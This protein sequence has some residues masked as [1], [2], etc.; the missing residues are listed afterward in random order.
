MTINEHYALL[1]PK[2]LNWLVA[3]GSSYAQ[4]CD[5]VQETFLKLWKMR[6]EILDDDAAVSGLVFTIARN[7]R[8]NETRDLRREVL[9][10]EIPEDPD[11]ASMPPATSPSDTIYLRRRLIAAFAKLPPLLRE[12]YT[13]FQIAEMSISEI[14]RETNATESLVKVRIHRAKNK[15]REILSDLMI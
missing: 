3:T 14:A 8:K 10:D 5:L 2:L 9:T 12:A 4:S 13:L 7:L 15:L 6:D 11:A 1:A